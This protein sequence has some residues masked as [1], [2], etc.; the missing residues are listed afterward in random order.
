MNM[1][2]GHQDEQRD[3]RQ[4]KAVHAAPTDKPDAFQSREACMHHEIEHGRD[5]NRERDGHSHREQT[6]EDQHHDN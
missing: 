3:R 5:Q 4:G 2:V 6:E 1:K